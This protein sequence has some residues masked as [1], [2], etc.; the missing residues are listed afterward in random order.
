MTRPRTRHRSVDYRLRRF[1]FFVEELAKVILK[2]LYSLPCRRSVIRM[3]CCF[4]LLKLTTRSDRTD[5]AAPNRLAP[6]STCFH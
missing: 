3:D 6:C 5:R 2:T 1:F 4:E